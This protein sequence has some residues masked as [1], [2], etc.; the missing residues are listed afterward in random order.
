M[1]EADKKRNEEEMIKYL[2]SLPPKRP[3]S[4]YIL[5]SGSVRE[6]ARKDNPR[7]SIT[8]IAKIIGQMWKS[9]PENEKKVR[10]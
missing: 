8:E 7:A 6:K 10:K 4:A 1:A 2:E 5:F 3:P 9:L